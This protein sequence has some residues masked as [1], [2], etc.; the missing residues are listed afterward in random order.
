MNK[1]TD[2]QQRLESGKSVLLAEISPPAEAVPAGVEQFAKRFAGKVHALGISDNRDRVGMA[3]LAAA[4]I[5][6]GQGIEPI[7]HVTTRDRN[8]IALVS[9]VLGAHALGIRNIFCTSGT[10]Q[11]LGHFR[12]SKNVYD[13][14]VIQLLQTS[15][16][17]RP[18]LPWWA[19][20]QLPGP[21]SFC[22]G[23]V[24]SP[25]ADPLEL[26]MIRLTK[27]VTAGAGFFVTQPVYDLERFRAWWA[28]VSRRGLHEKAAIL[29]GIELLGE[30]A[31]EHARAKRRPCPAVPDAVIEQIASKKDAA[32]AAVRRSTWLSRPSSSS[33]ERRGFVAFR[34]VSTVI[35]MPPWKSSRN[36][37]WERTSRAC[38]VRHPYEACNRATA[39]RGQ[40]GHRRL[41]RRLL[42]LPQLRKTRLRLWILSRRGRHPA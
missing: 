41:A 29:V 25:N 23:A 9:E 4:S 26:Q 12:A 39:H 5:V 34:S 36:P 32:S 33:A 2:L 15:T 24:A 42:V 20:R 40:T 21:S 8:R 7:L 28:E 10:H 14:D 13:I 16:T 19:K 37:H 35:R 1:P 30:H 11:T 31:L 3:A 22:L 6:A 17:W 27:K 18:T 38:Q